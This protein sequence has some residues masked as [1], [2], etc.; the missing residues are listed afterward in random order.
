MNNNVL[1]YILN[2]IKNRNNI[3]FII[4]N[5]ILITIV[6]VC[7]I[8]VRF[9]LDYNSALSK[10]LLGRT[11]V[12]YT[13]NLDLLRSNEH[14]IFAGVDKYRFSYGFNFNNNYI[15]LMPLTDNNY[16]NIVDG[17]GLINPG[18]VVCPKRLYPYEYPLDESNFKEFVNTKDWLNKS[19]SNGTYTFNIVGTY[20]N[21]LMDEANICYISISDFDKLDITSYNNNSMIIID[22]HKNIN[23][24]KSFL[25]SNNIGYTEEFNAGDEYLYLVTIP[26]FIISII[27]IIIL[28]ISFNFSKKSINNNNKTIGILR[29]Y[30]ESNNNITKYYICYHS[31]L[32]LISIIISLIISIII[33]ELVKP[34]LYEFYYYNLFIRI[35]ILG[36]IIFTLLYILYISLITKHFIN[37]KNNMDIYDLLN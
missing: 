26:P 9:T 17:H 24:V 5:T 32:L 3:T 6:F 29:A 12:V 15:S 4:I 22:N 1:K 18:D 7:L 25:T 23:S 37:K 36:I 16:I 30:G 33:Y 19:I 13:D 21:I 8:I 31:L 35:P 27:V 11:L 20:N 28:A 14:V 2:K 34:Y 10:N